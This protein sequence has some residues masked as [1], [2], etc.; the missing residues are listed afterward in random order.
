M[1]KDEGDEGEAEMKMKMK[2]QLGEDDALTLAWFLI[3]RD[4]TGAWL[5]ETAAKIGVQP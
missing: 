5:P 3:K 4:T 1:K 2:T